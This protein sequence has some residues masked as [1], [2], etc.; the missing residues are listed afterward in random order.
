[1]SAAPDSTN[2][3]RSPQ[4]LTGLHAVVTGAAGGIGS[5]ISRQLIAQG[6]TVHG[7]DRDGDGLERMAKDLGAG[8]FV[9]HM[10][11][12]ADRADLDPILIDLLD[13][14]ERRCDILVNNAGLS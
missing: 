5:A 4:P 11:D 8:S 9:A 3:A 14:L 6:A 10:V 1:M 12:L 7:L 2:A 13:R